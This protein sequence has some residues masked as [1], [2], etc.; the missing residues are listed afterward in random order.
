MLGGTNPVSRSTTANKVVWGQKFNRSEASLKDI[1]RDQLRIN[2]KVG[3]KLL[4]ND[5]ILESTHSKM[6]NFIVAIQNQLNFNKV[7]ET[8]I[9][10]LAA[11][12]PNG[13]DFPGQPAVPIKENVKAVIT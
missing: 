11:T 5:K 10:Q 9:A 2:S 12:H 4:A 1:V 8:Q 6:N 7:L 13:K 3:K